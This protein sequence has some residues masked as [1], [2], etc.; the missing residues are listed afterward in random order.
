MPWPKPP[1]TTLTKLTGATSASGDNTL[2]AA[3]GAGSQ[4]VIT[5]LILQNESSSATTLL[6]KAGSTAFLRVLCQNQGD[7]LA[8]TP[9]PQH[10]LALGANAALVLN[11]SA[12][13]A[14]GYSI[15]YYID[16]V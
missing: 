8:L 7:G 16:D 13:N 3:P 2:I 11:L 15:M 10:A 5:A 14:T 9:H 4:I 6:L 12:A 1:A